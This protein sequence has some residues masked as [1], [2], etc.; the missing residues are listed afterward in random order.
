MKRTCSLTI[1]TKG[2]QGRILKYREIKVR[3]D[4]NNVQATTLGKYPEMVREVETTTGQRKV[5]ETNEAGR[6]NS[7]KK[8]MTQQQQK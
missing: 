3:H 1:S 8:E 5:E 2:N 4:E 7:N 6:R